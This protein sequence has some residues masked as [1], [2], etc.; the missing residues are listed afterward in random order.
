MKMSDPEAMNRTISRRK[1]LTGGT[2]A[3]LEFHA[4]HWPAFGADEPGA[5]KLD[6][7]IEKI[8]AELESFVPPMMEREK[9]PGI[10]VA[11]IREA[12]VA[13]TKGFGVKSLGD[14]KP[15]D[16][17]TIFEMASL[18]KPVFA[19]ALMKLVE[20]G[21]LDLDKPLSAYLPNFIPNF[22]KTPKQQ[23]RMNEMTARH[24]LTHTS[25]MVRYQ[26][27]GTVGAPFI[28]GKHFEYFGDNYGFLQ[29]VIEYITGQPLADYMQTH[30]LDPFGL[31]KSSFIWR[32]EYETQ[33]A[34]GHIADKNIQGSHRRPQKAHAA[35][36]LHST[37]GEYAEFMIQIMRPPAPDAFRLQKETID[38]MLTS[39]VKVTS[40]VDWGLG[41]GLEEGTSG[42]AFWHW[43]NWGD[44]Q[45][46]AIGYRSAGIGVV[47]LTNSS[48]GLRACKEIVP[49]AI[50]GDHPVLSWG[51]LFS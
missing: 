25:G 21:K 51:K 13:W 18:T 29:T 36:S 7:P 42:S 3:L 38:K 15:V 35:A 34:G 37:A 28:P 43:G 2:G 23:E 31:K 8:A 24:L 30:L 26:K 10:S 48:T 50:G 5:L 47:V 33:A 32:P 20:T 4:C 14:P 9:V 44:F 39:Q 11:L 41:W 40:G 49:R 1:I 6:V 27:D 12:R 17:D 46:F 45:A 22:N 16:A 19:Y